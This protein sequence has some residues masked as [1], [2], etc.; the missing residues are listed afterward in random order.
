MSKPK[1]L[2]WDIET[3]PILSHIWRMWESNA[4]N[5]ERDWYMLC[6]SYKW[7][8][9]SKTHV[10][11]LPDYTLYETEPENDKDLVTDLWALIDEA[12]IL[13]HHNG[14]KFDLPKAN[15]KFI[16]HGLPPTSPTMYI[17]TCKIARAS[18]NFSSN[19]LDLLGEI[20]GLGR[21]SEVGGMSTWFGCISGDPKAWKK[22]VK[23]S[24]Q[25]VVL[26]EKVYDALRPWIKSGTNLGL[27]VEDGTPTCPK[28]GSK[29]VQ[30]RGTTKTN[31]G[32]YQRY[33]CQNE[34]CLAWSRGRHKI[35]GSGNPLTH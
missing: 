4:L 15:A 8:G 32:H 33:A 14:T 1:I 7:Y 35:K 5:I 18:F 13:I 28:C 9:E 17:D 21:K 19:K 27:M 10:V 22:M 29:D 34:S 23:Y 20:L 2:V 25:D 16:Q 6:Y 30:R 12:D 31:S 24:K 3:A 11:S 26:L